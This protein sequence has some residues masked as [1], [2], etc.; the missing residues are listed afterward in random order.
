MIRLNAFFTLKEGV[1]TEDLL[2]IT[3][4][5]I[6]ASRQDEGCKG[7][8]LFQS[9]TNPQVFLFCESWES[10]KALEKHMNAPH[11][12]SA[13]PAIGELTVD[14]LKLERFEN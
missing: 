9:T 1:N 6:D 2:K 8:D 14:G 12:V 3:T 5:L 7:Y 11:F 4:P 10:D 13:V